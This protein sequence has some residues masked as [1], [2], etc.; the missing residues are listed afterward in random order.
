MYILSQFLKSCL[1][2][3]W[4]LNNLRVWFQSLLQE[5]L[6]KFEANQGQQYKKLVCKEKKKDEVLFKQ[7]VTEVD[8]DDGFFRQIDNIDRGTDITSETVIWMFKC[9][10]G[11]YIVLYSHYSGTLC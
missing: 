7:I 5:E 4:R 2:I 1:I 6:E 11:F 3:L 10:H 8:D 9:A